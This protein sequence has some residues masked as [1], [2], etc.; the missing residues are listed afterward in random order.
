M[1]AISRTVIKIKPGKDTEVEDYIDQKA[2]EISSI[3]GIK[4]WGVIY[5]GENELTVVAVYENREDA[6]K[7]TAFVNEVMADFVPL[8]AAH[9]VRKIFDARWH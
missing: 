6:E 7:A 9:P 1:A 8:V 2:N 5:T 3:L 4:N